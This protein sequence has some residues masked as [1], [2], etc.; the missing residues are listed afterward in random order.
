MRAD[1]IRGEEGGGIGAGNLEFCGPP[2]E[3]ARGE[4]N[5]GPKNSRF[6][7]SIP[8][9]REEGGNFLV[10]I[11][12]DFYLSS[13][14]VAEGGRRPVG[15][16]ERERLIN[17]TCRDPGSNRGPLDLQSNALPTELSRLLKGQCH[18]IIWRWFFLLISFPPTPEFPIRTVS[19]FFENS[20]KWQMKKIFNQKN[21]NNFV[22]TPLDGRLNIYIH[23]CV[24]FTLRYLQPDVVPIVCHRCL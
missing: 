5:L 22:G 17:K 23:F 2:C 6:P 12:N 16:M 14:H 13:L 19:N 18:E 21:F 11:T 4:C 1:T 24:K 3:T 10:Q 9:L 8:T 20:R 7:V 15:Q